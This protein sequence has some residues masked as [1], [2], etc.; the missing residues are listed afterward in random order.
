MVGGLDF[1]VIVI[2]SH[3]D[4]VSDIQLTHGLFKFFNC[5]FNI[6]NMTLYGS[7]LLVT[8]CLGEWKRK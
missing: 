5:P 8:V 3:W 7:E 2:E 4:I 1:I 6:A